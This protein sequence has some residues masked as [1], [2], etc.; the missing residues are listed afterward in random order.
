MQYFG[1]SIASYVCV[2]GRGEQS[3][4]QM[5]TCKGHNH[6][7]P[8]FQEL[9]C[10]SLTFPHGS[11]LLSF[12]HGEYSEVFAWSIGKSRIFILFSSNR[13]LPSTDRGGGQRPRT[14]MKE[15]GQLPYI[16]GWVCFGNAT[17]ITLCYREL[18]S[19][20]NL[21]Q[22]G[23]TSLPYITWNALLIWWPRGLWEKAIYQCFEERE[24][25][26]AKGTV[27]LLRFIGWLT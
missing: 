13:S 3:P 4:Q 21:L 9:Y 15:F 24:L 23:V 25:L 18:I 20:A 1:C 5:G 2:L 27:L 12:L 16:R 26:G 22:Q 8:S 17:C 10:I 6:A 14:D 19:I 11:L 7:L